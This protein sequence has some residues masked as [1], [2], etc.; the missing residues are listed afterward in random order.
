[1]PFFTFNN[2]G[3]AGFAKISYNITPYNKFI[4]KATISMEGTQFGAPGNQNYHKVKAGLELY[5]RSKQ[6]NNLLTQKVYSN[7]ITASNLFQIVNQEKAK[8]STFLQ[9]GYQI[10]KT[11]TINPFNLLVS[12]E[13]SNS[14]LKTSIEFN[15]KISYYG[16]KNGLD[17]RFFAG[18]MLKDNPDIPF[19][20]LSASGR[21]GNDQYLF[22]GIYPDRFSVF[23]TTFWSRQMSISE[24]SLVSPVNE[25]LGYSRWLIS[26]SLTSNLPGKAALIPV[27]PFVNFLLNDHGTGI[28]NGSLFFY[29]AGVKVGLWNFFEIYIPLVVSG[30]IESIT[31]SFKDRIRIVFNLDSFNQVKLNSGIGIEIQ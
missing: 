26:L 29:E 5:F 3:L 11:G 9:F 2:S 30:N 21:S 8:M 18:T 1:M 16:K 19:Y 27:K 14:F 31:S 22:Q 10:E 17:I 23:P 25:T 12:S 13:S 7:F 28:G 24:G 6:M 4:R 15:Y 20:S